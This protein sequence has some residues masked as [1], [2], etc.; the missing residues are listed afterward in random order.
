[1]D[2]FKK[3]WFSELC[4]SMWNGHSFSMSVEEVLYHKQSK[5]QD[6]LVFQR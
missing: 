2:A 4:P 5:Y 3:G 6:V 1:M